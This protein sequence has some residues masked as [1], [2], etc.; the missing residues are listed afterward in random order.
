[1]I[2]NVF[3]TDARYVLQ[4][5]TRGPIVLVKGSGSRVWDIEGNEYIDCVAGIA[6]NNVGHCHPKVVEAIKKQVETLMHISNLFYVK[7][8]VELAEK[9]AGLTKLDRLFFC[10]SGTEAVEA[11][12]KFARR[13][14]KKKEFISSEGSFHGRTMGSLSITSKER[15]RDPFE[16]LVPGVSFVPYDDSDAIRSKITDDTAA[17][18]L[19][20]IQVESGGIRIPSDNY[21]TE[22]REICDEN[23]ALLIFDEVQ[24]GFGRTGEWFAKDHFGVKPDI[25]SMAKALGGGFPIGA[26]A[27]TESVSEKIEK[28]DHAA[29]FGGNP[30]AC[31]AALASIDVIIEEELVGRSR[32]MGEYFTKKIGC[33]SED[34]V[35]SDVRAKGLLIGLELN[36]DAREIT[37]RLREKGVLINCL[38]EKILRVVPPLVIT[39]EEIDTVVSC[40]DEVLR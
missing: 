16:P 22:V 37:E 30:L 24:T 27:I 32:E 15:Y 23:G 12:L 14:T 33:L 18:I 7:E 21:L 10:N 2:N 3:E 40:L 4:N 36:F 34:G 8:Q 1:M 25:M 9:L 28:G 13:V 39:K 17:V 35:I 20:P 26:V 5:Y 19:E 11:S 29:T 38:L 31:A 6:T